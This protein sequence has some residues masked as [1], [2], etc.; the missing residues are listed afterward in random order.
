M[1]IKAFVVEIWMNEYENKCLYNLAETCV[2]S[3]T[4]EEL[5]DF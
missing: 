2:E 5:L 3:I 1:K 4:F